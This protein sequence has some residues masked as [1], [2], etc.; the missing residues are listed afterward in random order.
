MA[1]TI[2]KTIF[3]FR[4]DTTANWLLNKD[5]IPA[6][7]EPCFDLDLHTLKIGDG[8]TTY[9]NLSA[10]GGVD[11]K[12][13]ADGKSVV[14]EDSVFKLMGFDAAEA[15]AQPRKNAD[16]NLEWVVPSTETVDGLQSAVAGLK[17]DVTNLQTSV[18]NIQS[19]VTPADGEPL[20]TRVV[21]LEEKMDGTGEGSVD[22]KIDAKINDFATKISDDDV[23]NSYKELIDYVAEHG[24]EAATMAAD[25]AELQDLV[26]G[27]SVIDQIAAAG[28]MTKVE[29]EETLL[30]KV[31]AAATLKHVKYEITDAPVGTLVDYG[32]KEIRVMVPSG[33][34]FVKQAVGAGGD[35]NNYYMT[36]KTYAPS[37]DVVGYI[38]HL[39]DQT[40]PEILTNFSTDKYGR[41]YQPTWLALAKYD[42]AIDTWTYY[43]ESSTASK[44]IGYDYRIDWYDANGVM[45]ASDSIRINLSN[46]DCHYAIEPYYMSKVVKGVSVG[47]TL[48]DIANGMVDVPVGAGL[49]ASEEV[50]VAEDGTL[51]IGSISWDKITEG[52][53]ELILD[54]G[55]AV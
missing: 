40:D 23:V 44:Y 25:I 21:T 4:R 10:I 49:K 3:Q 41:R 55:G 22:A 43:G 30:S 26:G 17:S 14:L 32:D 52:S 16:G 50:T 27:K 19:I 39:G 15:G 2:V 1:N 5:T 35:A 13:E 54:G 37:D 31:E 11:V 9:E 12:F 7:G 47:G 34:E 38:E 20:L 33:A 6:A 18:T 28:H 36:F 29:A 42:E 51:G 45:V 46:E 24:G 53:G 8:K 48:L